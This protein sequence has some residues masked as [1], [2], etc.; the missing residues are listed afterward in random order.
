MPSEID[1]NQFRSQPE[2]L[3][4]L[5]AKVE[6]IF[7]RTT[8]QSTIRR[9]HGGLIDDDPA[10]PGYRITVSTDSGIE[11][12]TGAKLVEDNQVADVD[13]IASESHSV[14]SLVPALPWDVLRNPQSD[15][16]AKTTALDELCD[17]SSEDVGR[18]AADELSRNDLSDAW[19]EH[20]VFVVEDI[21]ITDAGVRQR[22]RERLIE[23]A[24]TLRKS[25]KAGVERIVWS[26]IRR[27][28]S[29][30][31]PNEI[32]W[33]LDFMKLQGPV[34]TRLV[35]IQCVARKFEV[36]QPPKSHELELLETRV[37]DFAQKYLDPDV[38]A[39]G[40]NAAIAQN[41]IVALVALGSDKWDDVSDSVRQLQKRWFMRQLRQKLATLLA[42]RTSAGRSNIEL[43][44]L[45]KQIASLDVMAAI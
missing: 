26:A 24:R 18:F 38:F 45:R 25:P 35:A 16:G 4:T 31:A 42:A 37:A 40:G 11:H 9:H 21:A 34:D 14:E 3:E 10:G 41:A 23:I 13:A 30:S 2:F 7:R 6:E 8:G 43:E 28:V 19:R 5:R 20:L 29:F 36:A 1:M 17:Q 39:G 32:E 33:L 22:L 27:S 44:K 15:L 12:Y